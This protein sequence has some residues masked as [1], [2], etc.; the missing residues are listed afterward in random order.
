[1]RVHIHLLSLQKIKIAGRMEVC[2]DEVGNI[3]AG[4]RLCEC[5]FLSGFDYEPQSVLCIQ[6]TN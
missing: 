6:R 3:K 4:V 1:M 5:S 2:G